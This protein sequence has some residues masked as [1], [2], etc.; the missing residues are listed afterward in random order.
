M[1]E[2]Q[3][4]NEMA[5]GGSL[6]PIPADNKGL[7]NLPEKV[8]NNMGYMKAGG[9]VK[10]KKY[11]V[12]FNVDHLS[13]DMAEIKM[14]ILNLFE[15]KAEIQKIQKQINKSE[16]GY[17]VD[18]P[19]MYKYDR[20]VKKGIMDYL[21]KIGL[22]SNQI[23]LESDDESYSVMI[24][25]ASKNVVTELKAFGPDVDEADE[26]MKRG[27]KTKMPKRSAHSIELDSEIKAK[28]P[29]RRV[30]AS[31]NVYYESR[32]NHAD[33]NRKKKPYLE[34]GGK[35]EMGGEAKETKW[36]YTIG[37]L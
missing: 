7:P 17:D 13:D 34:M 28:K 10:E 6:K 22:K 36:T 4:H 25:N 29:G 14:S 37:G 19:I 32:P 26:E 31:G 18:S 12:S 11:D 27:G 21:K 15:N 1:K 5:K 30:S 33:E 23:E 16:D 20:L 9:S 3:K 8:R 35:M 24:T 2:N